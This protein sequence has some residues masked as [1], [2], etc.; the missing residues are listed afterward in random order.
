MEFAFDKFTNKNTLYELIGH[1][2][3][4]RYNNSCRYGLYLPDYW[5]K[6]NVAVE[7]VPFSTPGLRGIAIPAD[8]YSNDRDII[9]LS[10]SRS[11]FEKN[12]DCAHESIHITFHWKIHH[13][14][15][16]CYDKI[17]ANQDPFLEWQANEGAAEYLVPNMVFIPKVAERWDDLIHCLPSDMDLLFYNEMCNLFLVPQTVIK[18]RLV[19]LKYEIFQYISGVPLEK[20]Q[21]LSNNDLT[22]KD[23]NIDSIIDIQESNYM[24]YLT[25]VYSY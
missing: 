1:I 10:N 21:Y 13:K 16:S 15:F 24:K 6:Q 9:M 23:I 3:E 7:E 2:K 18:I 20:L 19:S 25:R 4:N 12:F 5:R 8:F 22:K 17:M 11:R 14:P